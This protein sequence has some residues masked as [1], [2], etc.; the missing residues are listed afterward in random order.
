MKNNIKTITSVGLGVLIGAVGMVANE[1]DAVESVEK[2]SDN[3]FRVTKVETKT[4]IHRLDELNG[5]KSESLREKARLQ[6]YCDTKLGEFDTKIEDI[7]TLLEKASDIITP[8]E[9]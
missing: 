7:N 6:A 2:I 3:E 8:N 4:E 9:E 5:T 1:S